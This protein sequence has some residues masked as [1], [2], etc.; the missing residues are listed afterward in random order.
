MTYNESLGYAIGV[1]KLSLQDFEWMTPSQYQAAI[2]EWEEE[3]K[4]KAQHEYELQRFNAWL[5]LAPNI[6]D[7]TSQEDLFRFPWEPL[8]FG[9]IK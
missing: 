6:K 2:K 9:K 5:C 8:Q 3:E 1:M 4:R 7:N